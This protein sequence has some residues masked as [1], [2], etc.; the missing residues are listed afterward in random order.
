MNF[1]FDKFELTSNRKK[2]IDSR[3]K[4]YNEDNEI[5]FSEG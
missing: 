1:T 4:M 5:Y 2:S 3:N